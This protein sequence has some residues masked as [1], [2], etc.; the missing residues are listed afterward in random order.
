[1]EIVIKV[2]KEEIQSGDSQ[3][4]WKGFALDEDISWSDHSPNSLF[5]KYRFA[6][7]KTLTASFP[8]FILQQ[9]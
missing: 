9:L 7:H 1:M 3:E 2:W 6:Y 8:S 5:T 4:I